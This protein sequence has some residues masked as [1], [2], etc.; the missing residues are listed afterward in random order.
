[1]SCRPSSYYRSS[2]HAPFCRRSSLSSPLSSSS[3]NSL[4]APSPLLCR[5]QKRVRAMLSCW[6]RRP[7]LGRP[8]VWSPLLV[9]VRSERSHLVPE[10]AL[11]LR[12][13][14]NTLP[15]RLR[16]TARCCRSLQ[17]FCGGDRRRVVSHA[18]STE[19]SPV[20]ERMGRHGHQRDLWSYYA[21]RSALLRQELPERAVAERERTPTFDRA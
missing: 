6:R 14:R 10:A 4:P 19:V 5:P 16:N 13:Q 2:L 1:M 20:R 15:V 11:E 12:R 21:G 7:R 8:K 18:V 3:E 17:T 9:E